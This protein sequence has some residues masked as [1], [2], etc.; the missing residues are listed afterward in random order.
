VGLNSPHIS[1][2][3]AVTNLSIQDRRFDSLDADIDAAKNRASVQNAL[4]RRGAMELTADASVGLQ[5]WSAK[6]NQPVQAK[7]LVRNG[8]LADIMVLAGQPSEGYSGSRSASA[9]V[10]G[11]A[12]NPSAIGAG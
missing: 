3:L 8:D 12:G 11:T 6:P 1:G 10:S 7:A 5:N 4:L 9:T 2:H